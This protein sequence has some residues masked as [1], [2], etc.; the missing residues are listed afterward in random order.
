MSVSIGPTISAVG[1]ASPS[2]MARL[3]WTHRKPI[4]WSVRHAI[5]GIAWLMVAIALGI[6]LAF[7]GAESELGAR[8]ASGYGVAGILGWFGNFII[9]ISYY[10]FPGFVIRA[11][12]L[13]RWRPMGAA[14]I[15]TQLLRSIVFGA[16]NFG[17]V[18]VVAGLLAS[19]IGVCIIGAIAI[20]MGGLMYSTAT[21]WTLSFA[22]RRGEA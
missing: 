10:L 14:E 3:V 16:F 15:S 13:Q 22:Y 20:A 8:I 21:M 7:M 11:R 4:D 12:S 5:G 2:T 18:L 6:T 9:G 1:V 19:R 17:L